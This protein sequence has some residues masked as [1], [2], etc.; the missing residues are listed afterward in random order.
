MTKSGAKGEVLSSEHV[1]GTLQ[2]LLRPG[3]L[4]GLFSFQASSPSSSLLKLPS[5]RE[6]VK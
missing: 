6:N 3:L 5:V 4:R 2:S 1:S